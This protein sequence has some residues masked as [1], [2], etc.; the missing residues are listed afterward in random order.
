MCV[1]MAP[2]APENEVVCDLVKA[3]KGS[4]QCALLAQ[5]VARVCVCVWISLIFAFAGSFFLSPRETSLSAATH[6]VVGQV[7]IWWYRV[8]T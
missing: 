5:T 2:V 4:C 7:G 8:E 3:K 6:T 1:A